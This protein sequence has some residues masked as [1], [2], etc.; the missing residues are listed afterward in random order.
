MIL[1]SLYNVV[2]LKESCVKTGQTEMD[3]VS[4]RNYVWVIFDS[5]LN[6]ILHRNILYCLEF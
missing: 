5:V 1:H 4:S 3:I 2:A 6:R